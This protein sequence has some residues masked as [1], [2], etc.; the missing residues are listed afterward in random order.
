MTVI[1]QSIEV[2]A[3]I[4]HVR[5]EWDQ[6]LHQMIIGPA[7][8]RPAQYRWTRTEREAEGG[9]VRFESTDTGTRV[10]AALEYDEG[11]LPEDV[12]EPQLQAYLAEDLELF[13]RYLEE[14]EER[15]IA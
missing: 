10:T 3:P 14:G 9:Q 7:R 13:R 1:R 11:D 2:L 6:F 12:T 8:P 15:A 5:E 4:D